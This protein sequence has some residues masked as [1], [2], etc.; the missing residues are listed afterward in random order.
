MNWLDPVF[1]LWFVGWTWLGWRVGAVVA[2]MR[3]GGAWLSVAL[4]YA[5]AS[6]LGD[7]LAARAGFSARAGRLWVGVCLLLGPALVGE[8]LARWWRVRH[9]YP[10]R[11]G[12]AVA[13]AALGFLAGAFTAVIACILLTQ[14]P[15]P[16]M[17]LSLERS[18]TGRVLLRSAPAILA[19]VAPAI[20]ASLQGRDPHP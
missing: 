1:W 14:V 12:D 4:T 18:W 19:L 10:A 15:L 13:G 5:Y 16:G 17:A 9:R 3:L 6:F 11:G 20:P 8:G 7:R 2:A